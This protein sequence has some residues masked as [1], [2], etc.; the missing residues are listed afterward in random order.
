MLNL[1]VMVDLARSVRQVRPVLQQGVVGVF[2][3]V[4]VAQKRRQ[5][6]RSTGIVRLEPYPTGR[7]PLKAAVT[8]D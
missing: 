5:L 2:V 6:V 3:A 8:G 1:A 4:L 7:P